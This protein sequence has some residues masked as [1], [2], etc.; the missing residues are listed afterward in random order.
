MHFDLLGLQW[1]VHEEG[2]NGVKNAMKPGVTI[3]HWQK[4]WFLS[5]A[6]TCWGKA[7]LTSSECYWIGSLVE[8]DIALFRP[9]TTFLIFRL[10]FDNLQNARSNLDKVIQTEP[11]W[12]LIHCKGKLDSILVCVPRCCQVLLT[13]ILNLAEHSWVIAHQTRHRGT[14][15]FRAHKPRKETCHWAQVYKK[16]KIQLAAGRKATKY[17]EQQGIRIINMK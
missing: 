2:E 15:R 11:E 1:R 17:T 10:D 5:R 8:R 14:I 6:L 3:C 13:L 7:E 9:W 12:I 16:Y 4:Q